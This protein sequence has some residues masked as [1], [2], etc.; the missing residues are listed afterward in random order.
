MYTSRRQFV[1]IAGGGILGWGLVPL[2]PGLSEWGLIG[3]VS[4][5]PRA[6]PASQGVTSQSI[7][8]FLNAAN[9]SGIS[10]HS[11]MLLRHGH[12]VAEGWWKPYEP[13]FIHS[14]YSLSKS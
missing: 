2:L 13:G 8:A 11:F 6:T 12:V 7:R 1:K 14:L 4:G 3:D 9:V 10:W 5:F